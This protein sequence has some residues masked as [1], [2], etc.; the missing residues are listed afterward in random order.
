MKAHGV[1]VLLVI[2][3]VVAIP[4]HALATTCNNFPVDLA[5][6]IPDQF[7]GDDQ[8][9]KLIDGS[10]SVGPNS[11][12][13]VTV[14]VARLSENRTSVDV[15]LFVEAYSS[16]GGHAL[17]TLK[18]LH[19]TLTDKQP[20][21]VRT[22]GL[23]TPPNTSYVCVTAAASA[24]N[25]CGGNAKEWWLNASGGPVTGCLAVLP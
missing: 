25:G 4:A 17:P 2:A 19:F 22:L 24:A 9:F 12:L 5:I 10:D 23:W 8:V 7:Q 15:D 1:S 21:D 11:A 3:S 14:R 16:Y 18:P 6:S 13:Y 20:I